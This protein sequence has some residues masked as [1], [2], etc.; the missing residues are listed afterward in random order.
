MLK[1]YELLDVIEI[2]P[3]CIKVSQ[4]AKTNAI[5]QDRYCSNN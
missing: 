3:I 4:K 1:K 5:W 2:L